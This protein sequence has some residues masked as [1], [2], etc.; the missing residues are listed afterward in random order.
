MTQGPELDRRVLRRSE[1]T[2]ASDVALIASEFLAGF[3]AITKIDRP[4]ASIFGSARVLEGTPTY[5]AARAAGRGF[6]ERGF[7]VVTGGGPGVMEA[8]NR[9]CKEAG[10][11][12]VGFN[13]VLPQE[14]GLNA[15]CDLGLT[16]DH[17]YAR[18]VMFVKAAEGFVIFPGGFG[19]Q[20]ELWEALTLIQTRKIGHFPVALV[21]SD[22]WDELLDWV[23]DEMLDD[24]LISP[25]DLDLVTITDDPDEAVE[26]IVSHYDQRLAEGSA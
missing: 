20:D 18:K 14:Q 25:H 16:F 5:D 8:A 19:T 6:A 3:Q 9:G 2:L 23:R 26:L 11:L 1:E 12:S 17:F 10:G 15:Y 21:D 7:A 13:I 24:G 4:A 22:Y